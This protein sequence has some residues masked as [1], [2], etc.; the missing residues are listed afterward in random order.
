MYRYRAE[1]AEAPQGT[2][3]ALFE[4]RSPGGKDALECPPVERG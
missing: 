4:P 1:G 2:D 3:E